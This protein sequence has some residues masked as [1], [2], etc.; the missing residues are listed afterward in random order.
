LESQRVGGWGAVMISGRNDLLNDLQ[1]GINF[2]S[3]KKIK[4]ASLNGGNS[5]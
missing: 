1:I 2:E 3:R 5:V 4:K